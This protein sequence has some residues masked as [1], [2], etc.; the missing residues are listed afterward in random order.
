MCKVWYNE[1]TKIE[2]NLNGDYVEKTRENRYKSLTDL[3]FLEVHFEYET[4]M[5]MQL[6]QWKVF[7]IM[8]KIGNSSLM[9]KES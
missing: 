9:K 3:Q 6:K 1:N 7:A 5:I 8:K 4:E 2:R